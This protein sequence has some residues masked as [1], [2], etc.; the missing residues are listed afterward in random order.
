MDELKTSIK[1][2]FVPESLHGRER[3]SELIGT[4]NNSRGS[5]RG[6]KHSPL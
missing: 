5:E 6:E 1:S 4:N 2:S 3:L